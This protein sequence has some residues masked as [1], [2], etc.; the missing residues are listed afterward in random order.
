MRKVNEE[1]DEMKRQ[2]ELLTQQRFFD[3][4]SNHPFDGKGGEKDM[5]VTK[6]IATYPDFENT[7]GR[8]VMKTQDGQ[9]VSLNKKDEQLIVEHGTWRRS[10]K[11]QDEEIEKRLP[12]TD[13]TQ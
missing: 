3:T 13:Y 4:T 10:Q 6:N 8:R 9:T 11:I 5:K 12:K 1:M 7:I 2:K